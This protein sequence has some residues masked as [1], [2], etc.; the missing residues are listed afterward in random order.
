LRFLFAPGEARLQPACLEKVDESAF[1]AQ[2]EAK[3]V[4]VDLSQGRLA[5]DEQTVRQC[6]P[7]SKLSADW[8]YRAA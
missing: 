2:S 5:R 7:L 3:K 8:K 6:W 1:A 4:G